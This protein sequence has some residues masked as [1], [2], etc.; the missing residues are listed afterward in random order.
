MQRRV[1]DCFCLEKVSEHRIYTMTHVSRF[2]YQWWKAKNC[3]R[4]VD[5]HFHEGARSVSL[6]VFPI[7]AANTFNIYRNDHIAFDLRDLQDQK[8]L[9]L[10]WRSISEWGSEHKART[11]AYKASQYRICEWSQPFAKQITSDA[12]PKIVDTPLT[13][14]L[15]LAYPQ[16]VIIYFG[17]LYYQWCLGSLCT[18]FIYF[19][20]HQN[21]VL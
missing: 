16:Y 18:I 13:L 4:S 17:V 10:R 9:T 14:I 8:L 7:E 15:R 5:T 12:R 21:I 20:L 2:D 11:F 19:L 3:W 1:H 6:S